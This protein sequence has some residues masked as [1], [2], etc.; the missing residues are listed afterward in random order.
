MAQTIVTAEE[1][2]EILE[3][4]QGQRPHVSPAPRHNGCTI[5]IFSL[6]VSLSLTGLTA[7]CTWLKRRLLP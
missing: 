1:V 2:I 5:T 6:H 3:E 4:A 7:V